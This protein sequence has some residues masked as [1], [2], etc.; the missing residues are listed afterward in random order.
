MTEDPIH[1]VESLQAQSFDPVEDSS[2]E[3]TIV[4]HNGSTVVEDFAHIEEL[5]VEQ[6]KV[7]VWYDKRYGTEYNDYYAARITDVSL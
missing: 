6:G 4:H 1:D 5:N 3:V 7:R 2:P